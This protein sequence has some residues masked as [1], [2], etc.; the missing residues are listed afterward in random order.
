[1]SLTITAEKSKVAFQSIVQDRDSVTRFY[2]NLRRMVKLAYPTLP[3]INQ[4][5]LVRQQFLQGLSRENQIEARRIGLEN[6]T[7]AILK[8]LEEIER[9][10]SDTT[11]L[12]I[13]LSTP[14]SS[15][16]QGPSLDDIARLIDSKIQPLKHTT[17]TPAYASAPAPALQPR[18]VDQGKERMLMLAYRLDFPQPDNEDELS[19]E[20]LENFIDKEL[21]SRLKT[22][23]YYHQTFQVKKVF[24]MNTSMYGYNAHA[25]KPR[26]SSRKCSECGK[27]G[28]TKS[29]CPK[30]KKG[31][32][33]K[34][35]NYVEYDTSS[36]D[37]SFDSSSSDD[38]D[39]DSHTCYGLKKKK[40]ASSKKKPDM[41]KPQ[42]DKN[43]IVNEVFQLVLKTM[44]ESFVNAVPKETVISIYNAMNAEFVKF[45]DPILSQLKG[46]PSI[47]TRE[48][49]WDSVKEIFAV[50]LQPMISVVS[51]NLVSNLI[52]KEEAPD[53]LHVDDSL[54]MPAGIGIVNRKSASDVI[55][56]K[57]KIIAPD[58]AKTM[59]V[60]KTIFDT[61]SDSSLV[62][63]NIV[64]RLELDVDKT[65][66]PD[67]S[68]VATKSDTMGT[69][70]G[71]GIS[72]YDSDNDKTIEDD[73]MVIKSDKDFLLL[74]VPWIDRAKAILDC[75]NR[76]LSIPIS[77]RK[78][79]I[80]PISLHKRKTNVTTL[81]IDSI[82][83]KKIRM[84]EDL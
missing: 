11:S 60:P 71:L 30:K 62:S 76:Q 13:P 28:H 6:P 16:Q 58:S 39:S 50:I 26:K 57:T 12:P 27:S 67:L 19:L 29:S 84:M 18:L 82:D 47:K 4:D 38:S 14:I 40:D 3:A 42:L 73:F 59:V 65:N 9:Y 63:S 48:K 49:I 20:V 66:A 56:I 54:W 21:R 34:K 7:S 75:G 37:S 44:V 36:S 51:N 22:D 69:T 78:K 25:D 80:I 32:G 79:V 46:S 68:G 10:R 23:D 5:E 17:P 53:N 52:R 74:G 77:Q 8:K 1:M 15:V 83:L 81:H 31:K 41:K 72:I 2:S 43:R 45:K 55:T 61:G 24:G 33:K 64:K 35:T 70:Y